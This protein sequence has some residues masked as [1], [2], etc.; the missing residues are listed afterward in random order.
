MGL[1][2]ELFGGRGAGEVA[3]SLRCCGRFSPCRWQTRADLCIMID[4]VYRK[5][6]VVQ[7]SDR[8]AVGIEKDLPVIIPFDDIADLAGEGITSIEDYLGI[9]KYPDET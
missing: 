8:K 5:L 3:E 9:E 2:A 6:K 7:D 4:P 1:P